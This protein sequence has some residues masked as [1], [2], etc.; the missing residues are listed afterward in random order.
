MPEIRPFP[1]LHYDPTV[2]GPLAEVIA[3]P[4]DVI[5]PA[6]LDRLYNRNP[7]NIVRLILNRESDRYSAAAAEL[8]A[9]KARGVLKRDSTPC[10]YYYAQDFRLRDGSEHRR[11]GLL[12]AVRLAEFSEGKIR[13]HERTFP[14][15][16]ADR[17]KLLHACNTNLSSIFGMYA[18]HEAALAPARAQ[19]EAELPWIDVTDDANER[20]RVWR[21]ADP[22]SIAAISAALLD[23]TIFIAD[24]HHRYETALNYRNERV[25][26]GDTDPD[27]AHQFILMYLACMEDPGL[28]IR[29][30]HRVFARLPVDA[31]TLLAK[32]DEAFHLERMPAGDAGAQELSR[33]IAGDREHVI[34]L[35]LRGEAAPI[36]L[37]LRDPGLVERVLGHL[38]KSVRALEV[39]ILDGLVLRS[40]LGIDVT[41]AGQEGWLSYTHEDPEALQAVSSGAAVAAFLVRA[42]KVSEVEE[43]CLADQVMPEKS[44]Y[45]YPKLLSGLVLHDL[46]GK[47]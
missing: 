36:L 30:T 31:P 27:A 7:H 9:W 25:A 41:Q 21:I 46:E 13:P 12:A 1:A 37:R 8:A 34:G 20:H 45:F 39:A 40:M 10:L 14:S 18:Q 3:P 17:L 43:V 15:A 29:P 33:R 47:R 26:A 5:S 28:V 4:Y 6:H 19:A 38:H 11:N 35:A 22:T 2:A 24:G 16:K 42:P 23:A 32:L 44:T